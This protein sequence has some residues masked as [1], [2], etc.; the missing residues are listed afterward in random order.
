MYKR[1]IYIHCPTEPLLLIKTREKPKTSAKEKKNAKL[2]QG[3]PNRKKLVKELYLCAVKNAIIKTSYDLLRIK[4]KGKKVFK[5]ML[6]KLRV[7]VEVLKIKTRN[8]AAILE[9]AK[10]KNNLNTTRLSNGRTILVLSQTSQGKLLIKVIVVIY[11]VVLQFL[12]DTSKKATEKRVDKRRIEFMAKAKGFST[13]LAV[14]KKTRR[15]ISPSVVEITRT[16]NGWVIRK[17]GV[18]MIIKS[19]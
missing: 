7:Q 17:N 6:A 16:G 10:L 4:G 2:T 15:V 13:R 19:L 18:I 5:E 3:S 8:I 11:T 9:P 14:N 1:Q 12:L